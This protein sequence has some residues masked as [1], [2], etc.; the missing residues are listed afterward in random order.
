MKKFKF[1]ALMCWALVIAMLIPFGSVA[2]SETPVFVAPDYAEYIPGAESD[3]SIDLEY[4]VEEFI[5]ITVTDNATGEVY[6]SNP[7]FY[8]QSTKSASTERQKTELSQL[9]LKYNYD[10]NGNRDQLENVGYVSSAN[11]TGAFY[12]HTDCVVRDQL[13]VY[14]LDK[15]GDVLPESDDIIAAVKAGE[16]ISDEVKSK[17]FGYKIIYGLGNINPDLYP[18][19]IS[20]EDMDYYLSKCVDENGNID[21]ELQTKML[22]DFKIVSMEKLN[23]DRERALRK[24]KD[25]S[26]IDSINL[27]H[28]EILE[29]NIL[30][31]P[32]LE[33]V[34]GYQVYEIF[35]NA[36]NTKKMTDLLIERW[37]SLGLTKEGLEQIYANIGF[38]AKGSGVSFEI[39]VVYMIEGNTFKAQIVT[40]EIVYSPEIAIITL[41]LLPHFGAKLGSSVEEGYTLL[42]DGSG[43]IVE[44]DVSDNRTNSIQI[45]LG[46]RHKDE[47]LSRT[48]NSIS[49]IP[50]FE[51]SILP[52]FGMKQDDRAIFAVVEKGYEIANVCMN[53]VDGNQNQYN[54][55]YTSFYPTPMDEIFYSDGSQAGVTMFPKFTVPTEVEIKTGEKKGQIEVQHWNYCRLPDTDM[56][57]R[58]NF[59]YG[60]EASYTGMANYFRQY[61]ID[62][63]GLERLEAS[64]NTTF[65]ADIYG[66]I[67]KKVGILGFPIEKKYAI[68][69]FEEAE[70]VVDALLEEVD[71]L[72][73]RYMGMANGSL[74]TTDYSDHFKPLFSLGGKKGWAEFLGK[75][76]DKN[77]KVYPDVNPTHVYV[78]K[79]FD[80]FMPYFDAVRTLGKQ[81]NII[82]NHNLATGLYSSATHEE[83][84]YY[85]PRWAVS[86]ANYEEIFAN[87]LTELELYDNKAVS[88]SQVGSTLSADF[89]ESLVIDRTQSARTLTAALGTYEDA[90]YDVAVEVG[91]YWTLPYA[92]LIMKIPTTSS[93][94]LIEDYEIPFL[95]MVI[96]GMIEYTGEEINTVQDAQYQILKCLEYGANLSARLMYEEDIVL[97]NTY[98][99]TLLYSMHYENW[100]EQIGEMYTT[101]NDVLKDVQDQYIVAHERLDTNVYVTTYENGLTIAVNYNKEDVTATFNG[102]EFNIAANGFVV[103]DKGD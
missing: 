2:A 86:P 17:I 62:L 65:Y 103:L 69:D 27:L 47:A 85:F 12:S 67:Q 98:Y 49:A 29:E 36:T 79:S 68:T 23:D 101:V 70:I 39:P 44:H 28:D 77:V 99:T 89:D 19:C 61:L 54:Y 92:D 15:E 100:L 9:Y 78:D 42:P 10:E 37:V 32:L 45:A 31:Y 25:Q 38:E 82:E 26:A 18:V 13:K 88:L 58:Y 80:G 24:A 7:V 96:H 91:H 59:L 63:Y 93:K 35:S 21:T 33:T 41:D 46:D 84:E 40:D 90:G 51:H 55:A 11:K 94:F 8:N 16:A 66:A 87:L 6:T 76:A 57:V 64:E 74:Y 1:G 5:G 22:K 53:L 3:L 81:A 20:V 73:V 75:M 72:S 50:Y 30:K 97:Q 43:A 95:Q 83:Q 4:V 48:G 71:G 14:A 56:Q 102:T 52:V 60:E 34:E